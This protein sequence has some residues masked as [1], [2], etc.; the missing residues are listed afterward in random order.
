[1]PEHEIQDAGAFCSR[2]RAQI[3]LPGLS[4][5]NYFK[6]PRNHEKT[7]F[8]A[9]HLLLRMNNST[10]PA[11]EYI[12]PPSRRH[13]RKLP[14]HCTSPLL[15]SSTSHRPRP[16]HE[17]EMTADSLRQMPTLPVGHKWGTEVA[18]HGRPEPESGRWWWGLFQSP[19]PW[20]HPL[21]FPHSKPLAAAKRKTTDRL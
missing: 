13:T 6:K 20:L 2:A 15:A 17:S 3:L 5:T 21:A 7:H 9:T 1:M 18:P 10:I 11:H 19:G 16:L 8:H 14:P 12:R 4:M